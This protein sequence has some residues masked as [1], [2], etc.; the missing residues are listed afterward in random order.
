MSTD[1]QTQMLVSTYISEKI[2]QRAL[3]G[4]IAQFWFLPCV[5]ALALLPSGASRWASYAVV[6]VLLSY[7]N[8]HPMQVA[9]ASRNSNSVRNRTV[10]AALYNMAVQISAIIS[11]NIYREDDKPEY[12]RGNRVLIG[13]NVLN[14]FL[15]VAV[16]F[17]YMWRNKR[18]EEKWDAM[19]VA[20][21]ERYL[22]TTA[23]K[24]SRRLEFRFVH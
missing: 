4:L 8:P 11:A 24:A 17:Y 23:D 7:P 13:I 16:K 9:W 2:N 15:Y 14:I 22:D 6:T 12:R 5:I 10:S 18:R 19:S 21:K 3:H 20:E 1:L